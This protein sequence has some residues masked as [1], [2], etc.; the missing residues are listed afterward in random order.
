MN[1]TISSFQKNHL[2]S[3]FT[4]FSALSCPLDAFLARYF[5]S[6]KSIGSKDRRMI[7]EIVY[8]IT[9][10]R[11]LIDYFLKSPISWESRIDHFLAFN[12]KLFL[13]DPT[14]LPYI[15]L[16]FPKIFYELLSRSLGEEKVRAF[17]YASNFPAP[18]MLRVNTLKTSREDLLQKWSL[19]YKASPSTTS[20]Y[21][22]L[23]PKRENF[24]IFEEFK[25]GLFEVQDE[26]SQL[27]ADLIKAKPGDHILD[28]CCG[29]G[30]KTLAF[31]HKLN[32]KGQIYLH[33]IRTKALTEAR[34][35][36]ARAGIQNAQII[37][38]DDTRINT[39]KGKMDWVLVDAPCSG[40]GTLRR[41]PDMKWKF[42][43]EDLEQLIEL[44]RTIFEKALE[45]VRPGGM[46]V[47]ATC[48]VLSQ[49]NE[50]Q[51]N[52]FTSRY[53]FEI[54]ENPF[55]SFPTEGGMDGFFGVI[56]QKLL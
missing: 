7:S 47:Y 13:D 3:L 9:R 48:S 54:K 38:P 20:P 39:L 45:F 19:L 4:Q 2:V 56:L 15:R 10:W 14:I 37:G 42:C 24:F 49:E 26:G 34:K 21:G 22:I 23:F 11:G 41:N 18:I 1:L 51:L 43:K 27:L 12:P 35:R 52:Y 17:C 16:S 40:T 28:Y 32:G 5:R 46:I 55:R 25:E 36:L 30:G 6:H 29:S 53:R 50:D 33:D 44:Q 31:A 8:G